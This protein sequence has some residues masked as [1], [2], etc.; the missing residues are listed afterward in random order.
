VGTGIEAGWGIEAG[1]GI[2]TF[3]Y[4]ISAKW[5]LAIR[6]AAG[7]YTKKEIQTVKSE[8]RGDT[9]VVLG[10]VEKP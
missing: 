2:I 4:G 7:L 1:E 5:I 10:K 9:M 6:V 8:L 3:Y